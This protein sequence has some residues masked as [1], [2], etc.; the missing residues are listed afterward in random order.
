D[1]ADGETMDGVTMKNRMLGEAYYLR[2]HYYSN[3]VNLFGG[4]PIIKEAYTLDSD[5]QVPRDTYEACV[6]FIV[7]DLD[8]AAELLPLVHTG[9]NM[10]R[11]T[12]GAALALK[13]RI[14]LYAASD[15]HNT[16]VFPGYAHPELISYT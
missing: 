12:K 15:L 14:L 6:N 13:S 8:Q 9:D 5:F 10:G 7:E 2:A 16:T 4:V 1:L 3:L 11:A